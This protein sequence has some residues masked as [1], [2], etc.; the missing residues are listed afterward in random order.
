MS[1]LRTSRLVTSAATRSTR[2]F[3]TQFRRCADEPAAK[4]SSSDAPNAP[5]SGQG[6]LISQEGP[7]AAMAR[8]APDYN[9][10]VDY[11]TSYV[12]RHYLTLDYND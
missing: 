5:A 11:R 10:A 4:S 2:T 9:V 12:E 7:G 8:H 6:D 3:S 1:L